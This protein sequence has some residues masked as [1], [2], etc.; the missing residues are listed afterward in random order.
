VSHLPDPQH[1]RETSDSSRT[2]AVEP[3]TVGFEQQKTDNM[4]YKVDLDTFINKI[5]GTVS[6]IYH[7]LAHMRNHAPIRNEFRELS[8]LFYVILHPLM[9]HADANKECMRRGA[10][11]YEISSQEKLDLLRE[12][13]FRRTPILK[14]VGEG[15]AVKMWLD[16][17]QDP[18]GTINYPSGDPIAF[19]LDRDFR[20]MVYELNPGHCLYFD[21]TRLAYGQAPCTDPLLTV[22]YIEKTPKIMEEKLFLENI[23]DEINN[24]QFLKMRKNSKTLLKIQLRKLDQGDCPSE[25]EYSLVNSLG[26]DYPLSSPR[27][28]DEEGL[29]IQAYHNLIIRLRQDVASFNQVLFGG[30]F[31]ENLKIALGFVDNIQTIFDQTRQTVCFFQK[32][33]KAVEQPR[34]IEA[35][36]NELELRVNASFNNTGVF[37]RQKISEIASNIEKKLK[38]VENNRPTHKEV[39]AMVNNALQDLSKILDTSVNQA[40]SKANNTIDKVVKEIMSK[41]HDMIKKDSEKVENSS[42]NKIDESLEG[43]ISLINATISE[44]ISQ[45]NET[46]SGHHHFYNLSLLDMILVGIAAFLAL[47]GFSNTICYAVLRKRVQKSRSQSF[48]DLELSPIV[49]KNLKFGKDKVREYNAEYSSIETLP[50]PEPT[51]K[52]HRK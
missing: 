13:S 4:T 10:R 34:A 11:L 41:V 21:A 9:N 32:I 15:H 30:K 26:L 49:K 17:E 14:T 44:V 5:D 33:L 27:F 43:A 36:L 7:F 12:M 35:I 18:D 23:N 40:T 3:A 50:S 45:T 22:C 20:P 25:K 19:F 6:V 39:I 48:N 29:D 16:F 52:A 31:E 42:Q 38:G 24:L 8:K 2:P 46:L 51:R 28:R 1:N 37:T 47:I